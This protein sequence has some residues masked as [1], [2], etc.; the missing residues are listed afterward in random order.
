MSS[1][2]DP[3]F[4]GDAMLGPVRQIESVP[5]RNGNGPRVPRPP[6]IP[7]T[8]LRQ[9]PAWPVVA[10][11][12]AG[13]LI[14]AAIGGLFAG[15]SARSSEA[16]SLL[17][18]SPSREP[19]L[20][21]IATADAATDAFTATELAWLTGPGLP[22][23]IAQRIG[24]DLVGEITVTRVGNSSVAEIAA[25]GATESIALRSVQ[26]GIDAYTERR[27]A[28]FGSALDAAI[29]T[30][31]IALADLGGP[32][33]ARPDLSSAD[34][35]RFDRLV[36]ARSDLLL[37]RAE[38]PSPVQI[39]EPPAPRPAD[40]PT[41]GLLSVLLGAVLGGLAAATGFVAWRRRTDLVLAPPDALAVTTRLLHPEIPLRKDW[42]DRGLQVLR[43]RDRYASRM[44]AGQIAN[45][46]P[47]DGKIV[48]VF[49][50]SPQS[51]TRAVATMLAVGFA[52]LARTTL[53]EV[54]ETTLHMLV[55]SPADGPRP[56]FGASYAAQVDDLAIAT[57][58]HAHGGDL[59]RDGVD[60]T[61]SLAVNVA[62][63][64]GQ[65]VVVDVGQ[66]PGLIR[67]LPAS[68]EVI[69]VLG[70]G[71]D[72]VSD[73]A[74]LAAAARGEYEG[75]PLGVLTRMPWYL[76]WNARLRSIRHG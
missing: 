63:A 39:L 21:A 16:S 62:H 76:Q 45:R 32:D 50:P 25:T 68:A 48:A 49:G 47:L 70:V 59:A 64:Q 2:T 74:A 67:R 73:A 7:S 69:I 8:S 20:G 36:S 51:G 4:P 18:L 56:V 61:W 37:I 6:S 12:V 60:P 30:T 54:Q 24:A 1:G 31:D 55:P 41:S 65:C 40:G 34:Q 38:N 26:A 72:S 10:A 44:L 43:R 3:A 5:T 66:R 22:A 29:A 9:R 58:G 14:G 28:Q 33:T 23:A 53:V 13:V 42:N 46:S 52:E 19:G 11:V 57:F 35:L 75:D 27:A 17:Q 71:I 15:A